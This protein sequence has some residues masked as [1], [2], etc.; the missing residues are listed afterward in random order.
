MAILRFQGST[1]PGGPG[2]SPNLIIGT[3]AVGVLVLD[4]VYVRADGVFDRADA[5][6]FATG[7]PLGFASVLDVPAGGDVQVTYTGELDGFVGLVPG[8]I[9]VMGTTPGVIVREGDT[10]NPNY[11]GSAGNLVFEVGKAL[12]ATKLFVNCTR[13]YHER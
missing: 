5:T 12:S 8:E 11:P 3:Y 9:Y 7:R 6:A 1:I 10:G 4:P 2:A 13:D